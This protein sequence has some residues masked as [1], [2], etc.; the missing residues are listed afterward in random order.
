M[1]K[2]K[3]ENGSQNRFDFWE[4]WTEISPLEQ[5]A[6]EALIKARKMLVEAVGKEN[7]VV[8]YVKGSFVRR[9]M[10]SDSDVDLV[11]IVTETIYE[12]AAWRL[13][14]PELLPVLT[15]PLSLEELKANELATKSDRAYDFRAKPDRFLRFIHHYQLIY[16]KPLT[17]D[18]FPMRNDK[19][20]LAEEQETL[21]AMLQ[22][23]KRGEI[24]LQT[25]LKEYF[26]TIETEMLIKG[27]QVVHS[28]KGIDDSSKTP[29]IWFI[30]P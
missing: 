14:I 15:V 4:S 16:G 30:P 20:V 24:D 17:V 26:W 18:V 8:A 25:M 3:V 21:K 10:N 13:N 11:P 19:T 23:Y 2:R 7:L 12:K 29:T 5:R 27:E 9:E 28:F 6:I 1:N 22:F